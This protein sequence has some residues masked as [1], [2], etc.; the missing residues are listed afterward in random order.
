MAPLINWTWM[1]RNT[2]PRPRLRKIC[3]KFDV[4]PSYSYPLWVSESY[5]SRN[6]CCHRVVCSN[7]IGFENYWKYT[8]CRWFILFTYLHTQW[9]ISSDWCI[10]PPKCLT[11]HVHFTVTIQRIITWKSID[12]TGR[13]NAPAQGAFR[14]RTGLRPGRNPV[15]KC[16][17][18]KGLRKLL[19]L[20]NGTWYYQM[21]SNVW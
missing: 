5:R 8:Y 18:C 9:Q 12:I 11:T 13:L 10:A 20:G 4:T 14:G 1:S 21:Q 7:P 15:P 19:F 17:F 16:A 2:F 3:S 6:T